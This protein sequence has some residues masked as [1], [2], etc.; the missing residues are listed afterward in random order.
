MT[1]TPSSQIL[2]F[3]PPPPSKRGTQASSFHRSSGVVRARRFGLNRPSCCGVC[4]GVASLVLALAAC[5]CRACVPASR[6]RL[7]RAAKC[8]PPAA[9]HAA[10]PGLGV[11]A[12]RLQRPPPASRLCQ[13]SGRRCVWLVVSTPAAGA[14]TDDRRLEPATRGGFSPHAGAEFASPRGANPRSTPRPGALRD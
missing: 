11:A 12:A 1:P 4:C 2:R 10:C 5:V 8:S 13:G 3:P 7:V 9:A 14:G 6:G